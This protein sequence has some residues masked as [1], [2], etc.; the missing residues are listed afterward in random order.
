MSTKMLCV[1]DDANMLAGFQRN[2]RKQFSVDA[3]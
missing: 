1:D 2:L 3:A